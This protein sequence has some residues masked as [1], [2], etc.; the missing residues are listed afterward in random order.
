MLTNVTAA[1]ISSHIRRI[2]TEVIVGPLDG[3]DRVCAVSLD[4]IVT[5][6]TR[7][8]RSFVTTLNVDRMNEVFEA[9]HVAFDLY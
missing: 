8:L 6:P 7:Y 5:F 9:I 1:T 3:F 2:N 4:N